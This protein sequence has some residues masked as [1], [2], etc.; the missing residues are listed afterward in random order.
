MDFLSRTDRHTKLPVFKGNASYWTVT[1]ESNKSN[2]YSPALPGATR[3]GRY[4]EAA[5]VKNYIAL[6]LER[7][8]RLARCDDDE[9]S[10]QPLCKPQYGIGI[11]G[12]EP[13]ESG[14]R[15]IPHERVLDVMRLYGSR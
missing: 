8:G 2:S 1:V 3:N 7:N 15:N 11:T 9:M 10:E 12:T 4:D 5:I 13:R 6:V 14:S